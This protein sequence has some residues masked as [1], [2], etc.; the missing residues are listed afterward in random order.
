MT[1]KPGLLGTMPGTSPSSM[2]S[3]IWAEEC[4]AL[5]PRP[6][7]PQLLCQAEW[8]PWYYIQKAPGPGTV[9]EAGELGPGVQDSGEG[10]VPAFLTPIPP[11]LICPVILNKS[12]GLWVSVS[13]SVQWQECYWSP[14]TPGQAQAVLSLAPGHSCP[15]LICSLRRVMGHPGP[16]F[17]AVKLIESHFSERERK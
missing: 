9:A 11:L 15:W 4:P 14:L 3:G 17:S 12:Q 10:S 8:T 13:P 1:P 5:G 7:R 16:L 2:R 6:P